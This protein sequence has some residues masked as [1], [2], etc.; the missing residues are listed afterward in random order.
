MNVLIFI[1]LLKLSNIGIEGGMKSV[2]DQKQITNNEPINL[3]DSSEDII[4]MARAENLKNGTQ[5]YSLDELKNI[6]QDN[7]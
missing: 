6:E 7:I 3:E 5:L 1:I 2:K 4:E